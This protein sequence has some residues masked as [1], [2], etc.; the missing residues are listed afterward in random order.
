MIAEQIRVKSWSKR[1]L[2]FRPD[3]SRPW[4]RSHACAPVPLQVE[5]D[6][7]RVYFASRDD[8]NRSHVGFF[9]LD[10]RDNRIL[11]ISREPLLLPGPLG[12]F[13]DHGIYA[14]CV[15][16]DGE[17]LMMYTIGWNPGVPQ[18]LFYASIGL[19][20]SEDGGRTFE[21]Y[22]PAPV[23][24]RSE[25]DP[26]SVTGPMVQKEGGRYRMWYVSG[27]KWDEI[28]AVPRSWYHIKYAES[29]DG[30]QWE[31][32]GIVSID[33]ATPEEK[34]IGRPYVRLDGG[35]YR[36]WYGYNHGDG[37]R[38]G[39]AES[40]DGVGFTRRDELA[41]ISGTP[42]GLDGKMLAHPHV[43]TWR[44]QELMFYNG[45]GF[46]KEGV[47]LAVRPAQQLG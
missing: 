3:K 16:P 12:N 25:F 40:N 29:S 2:V 37:Y 17:R 38:I 46:G 18:P 20:V 10:V 27:Y 14:S 24:G 32:Q 19:A 39:Y 11:E 36:A 4:M 5:E 42:G 31:R 22:S 34:N 41:G 44:D 7:F 6:V 43:L 28:D 15:V 8:R 47:L 13:D 45:D 26:C 35:V 23:L 21:R 1:G 33:H 30:V 9:E